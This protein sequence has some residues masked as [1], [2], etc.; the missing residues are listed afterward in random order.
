M[1]IV[2]E[3]GTGHGGRIDSVRRIL[4]EVAE[5]SFDCAKFQWVI[6]S[7]II[8]PKAGLVP[9][10]GGPTPLYERFHALEQAPDFYHVV[11]RET[12]ARGLRFLCTPFG[13]QSLE[14]LLALGVDRIKIAS[15][16]LV[17][18]P[19][20]QAVSACGISVIASTGVSTLADIDEANRCLKSSDLTF[21]HCVTSYPAPESD[22]N[23]RSLPIRGSATGRPWGVSDHSLDPLAVP[24]VSWAVG[25]VML[26]KHVTLSHQ[27]TGLDDPVALEPSQ[28][29]QMIKELRA[30]DGEANRMD[31]VTDRLG[32]ERVE[33]ILGDQVIRLAESET[34]N[35][36]RTNRS[37]HAI[38]D[39][40]AG[41]ALDENTM[42][43]LRTEKEL[44]PGI[45]PRF[46]DI[47]H[48]KRVTRMVPDGAGIVWDD[49]F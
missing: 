17:H 34:E 36:G 23:M 21:L 7:E 4:D 31:A 35:Y 24:M 32:A 39:L 14:G 28:F 6:A 43:V 45:H 1:E 25:A 2:A 41:D 44:R 10:P 5:A 47:L 48:R 29:R 8:H 15:P 38:R 18:T 22:Y 13:A 30:L 3:I 37:I 16:E 9:L 49:L 11:K 26:E 42:A 20:L 19:L 12:E 33:R 40:S 27:G 46:F